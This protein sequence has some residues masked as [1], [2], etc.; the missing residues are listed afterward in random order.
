MASPGKA[1]ESIRHEHGPEKPVVNRHVSPVRFGKRSRLKIPVRLG[2]LLIAL[3]LTRSPAWTEPSREDIAAPVGNLVEKLHGIGAQIYECK[4]DPHGDLMW[5]F[6]EPLAS[7]MIDG[8]TVGRHFAGPTWELTNGS[9][10]TGKVVAQAPAPSNGDIPW[11]RLGVSDGK[12]SGDFD[13]VTTVQRVATVG[14]KKSGPCPLA[15]GLFA[16][17]Y[18]ADYLFWR[19]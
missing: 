18:A 6:R 8:R 19:P 4:A 15:G 14:G 9:R 11:L 13:G 2:P 17:P 7:L 10:I 16:E 12:G 1:A 3:V 5:T